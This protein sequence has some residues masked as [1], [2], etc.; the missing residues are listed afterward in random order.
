MST[1][2]GLLIGYAR[3]STDGQDLETQR[4]ALSALGVDERHMHSDK[5]A[6]GRNRDRPGLDK[7]LAAV[8]EG[9]TLVVT[10]LDRLAR[11]LRDATAI[12]DEL[13]A[14]GV[15]LSIAGSVYDPTDPVGK[16]LFAVLGMVAEFESDLIRARTREGMQAP[17]VRK[18]LTGR[19]PKLSDLQ[20]RHLVALWRS[21]DHT[22]AELCELFRIGRATFYR[23]LERQEA[24]TAV[25]M[26]LPR[27][28]A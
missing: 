20:Q 10:K 7:A 21:N 3:V 12:A 27:A 28:E 11:S 2:T 26:A 18:K 14:K 15:R 8:R 19:K 4:T 5:G 23:V 9:D 6:T 1:A 25:T 17:K 22:V 13:T 16:M 24:D